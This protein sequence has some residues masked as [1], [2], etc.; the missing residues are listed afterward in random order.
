MN[1]VEFARKKLLNGNFW[2]ESELTQAEYEVVTSPNTHAKVILSLCDAK[3]L[4]NYARIPTNS[5]D[6]GPYF[7]LNSAIDPEVFGAGETFPE[8]IDL[9]PLTLA[10]L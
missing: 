10:T 9:Q 4:T 5:L 7:P 8:E 6:E 1:L 2:D 3:F